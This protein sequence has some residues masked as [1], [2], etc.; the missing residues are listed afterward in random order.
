MVDKYR[1]A[2]ES[3]LDLLEILAYRPNVERFKALEE[4]HASSHELQAILTSIYTETIILTMDCVQ[5]R[6]SNK[7]S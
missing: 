3:L 2:F 7:L 4:L 5:I 6:N 1:G